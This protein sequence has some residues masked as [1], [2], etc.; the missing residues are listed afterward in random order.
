M[1]NFIEISDSTSISFGTLSTLNFGT[2]ILHPD[3]G[4]IP[5]RNVHAFHALGGIL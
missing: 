2:A 4:K 1:E 5:F 3:N